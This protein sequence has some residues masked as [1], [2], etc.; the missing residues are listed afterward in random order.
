MSYDIEVSKGVEK[1][2]KKAFAEAFPLCDEHDLPWAGCQVKEFLQKRIALEVE[3][4]V[5]WFT[6]RVVQ[7]LCEVSP[8]KRH[9]DDM[10]RIVVNKAL[11]TERVEEQLKREK[12]QVAEL[13]TGAKH[14][15]ELCSEKNQEIEKLKAMITELQGDMQGRD[16]CLFVCQTIADGN[17]ADGWEKTEDAAPAITAVKKLRADHERLLKAFEHAQKT[18]DGMVIAGPGVV[19]YEPWPN[20]P[21]PHTVGWSNDVDRFMAYLRTDDG[22][23]D[24]MEVFE[25][26]STEEKA[27]EAE[28]NSTK[29]GQ[30]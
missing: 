26:Y 8:P 16:W 15:A 17:A 18:A 4:G 21:R 7:V 25:C 13:R 14:W 9:V 12:L 28:G 6:Q 22:E 1:E 20:K 11:A 5:R 23:T 2:L 24:V 30:S 19:V 29:E 3:E 10:A 27:I